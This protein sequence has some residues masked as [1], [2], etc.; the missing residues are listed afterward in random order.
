MQLD[1][2]W[3]HLFGDLALFKI[4]CNCVIVSQNLLP[5]FVTKQRTIQFILKT[6]LFFKN[7]LFLNYTKTINEKQITI[8]NSVNAIC[9]CD[10]K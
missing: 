9:Y 3:Q 7:Y 10:N 2:D 5:T 6:E 4:D 1:N 8:Y